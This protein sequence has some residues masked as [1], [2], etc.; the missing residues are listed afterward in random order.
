MKKI[1]LILLIVLS[2]CSRR[3]QAFFQK[4]NSET[5]SEKPKKFTFKT[6]VFR[7][8]TKNITL[9]SV[10][11]SQNLSVDTK[12]VDTN[13]QKTENITVSRL[14]SVRKI[15]ISPKQSVVAS[16]PE[17][18]SVVS[19]GLALFTTMLFAVLALANLWL[20][21]GGISTLLWI[22]SGFLGLLGIKKA[23]LIGSNRGLKLAK[24]AIIMSFLALLFV[25]IAVL[26]LAA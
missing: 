19:F 4:S 6:P 5:Q 7:L 1:L 18:L 21:G 26:V 11:K 13:P 2:A 20:L 9:D 23:K 15:A 3:P 14:V 24:A 10:Y 16:K 22:L 17:K 25:L 12:I 8:R